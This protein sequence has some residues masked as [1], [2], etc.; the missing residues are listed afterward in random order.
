[1]I[2][3]T[4]GIESTLHVRLKK[5]F[6]D[7]LIRLNEEMQHVYPQNELLFRSMEKEMRSYS[8]SVRIFRDVTLLASV[9]I[10]F[11]ILMGLI[12]YVNDEIRLRSKEIAIRKV[13]GAEVSGV[14]RLLTR[15][16]L[17]LVIPAVTGRP[18]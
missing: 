16:V 3:W 10:L 1:M 9:T 15:D 5:P 4:E 6:D 17:W 8:E 2:A 7:N 14:L 11:I 13:N 18:S 12:G